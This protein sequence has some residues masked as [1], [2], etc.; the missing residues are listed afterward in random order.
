MNSVGEVKIIITEVEFDSKATKEHD[1]NNLKEGKLISSGRNRV[2]CIPTTNNIV[3]PTKSKDSL[4]ILHQSHLDIYVSN[5]G[6]DWR[7]YSKKGSIWC[8]GTNLSDG[9]KVATTKEETDSK[10]TTDQHEHKSY[11]NTSS[12]INKGP[13]KQAL[14][15]FETWN[16]NAFETSLDVISRGNFSEGDKI[17]YNRGNHRIPNEGLK[18]IMWLY[19]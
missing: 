17:N 10:A 5:V 14:L 18:T 4:E 2:G 7:R 12:K 3:I 1:T 13:L 16:D 8:N 6:V 15:S 11:D 9:H 19:L